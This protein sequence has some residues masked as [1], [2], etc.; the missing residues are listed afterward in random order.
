MDTIITALFAISYIAVLI[1]VFLILVVAV[2][3][4]KNTISN[5]KL[6]KHGFI[7]LLLVILL[8]PYGNYLVVKRNKEAIVGEEDNKFTTVFMVLFLI[9]L[10]QIVLPK[11]GYGTST[12][13]S[14]YENE[15]YTTYYYATIAEYDS[16]KYVIKGHEMFGIAEIQRDE[17]GRWV[18]SVYVE[19]LGTFYASSTEG[20][21]VLEEPLLMQDINDRYYTVKVLRTK[22]E[23]RKLDELY[24]KV[25]GVT[26]SNYGGENRQK[27][28]KKMKSGSKAIT[29]VR[30]KEN[31]FD[32]HAVK[33][34]SNYGVIGY[35]DK[36]LAP[37]IASNMDKGNIVKATVT[38]ITGG[39]EG[40]VNLGCNLNIKLYSVIKK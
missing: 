9:G 25:A 22:P 37:L 7:D 24:T 34:L 1:H 13:G 10:S 39:K 31:K 28:L 19:N 26:Y 36:D 3:F 6:D 21:V 5:R 14:Y 38:D 29:L 2:R 23:L 40:K 32:K 30:E 33:V 12:I 27:L 8:G 17:I 11:I 35:I 20:A 4:I 15:K 18:N 16:D